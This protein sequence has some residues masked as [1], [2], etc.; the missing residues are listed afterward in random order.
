[1]DAETMEY[2]QYAYY[3]AIEHACFP[4]ANEVDEDDYIREY[5]DFL[6]YLADKK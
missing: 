6:R 3:Y 5:D 1:L 4:F 2:V